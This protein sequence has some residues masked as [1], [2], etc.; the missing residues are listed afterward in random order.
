MQP[1]TAHQMAVEFRHQVQID[2]AGATVASLGYV[3][4]YSASAYGIC[5]TP[6]KTSGSV[7]MRAKASASVGIARRR[8][9]PFMI[10]F[11]VSKVGA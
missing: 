10:E 6:P 9:N 5:S 2:L 4:Q 3:R 8:V 11:P 1:G 7:I